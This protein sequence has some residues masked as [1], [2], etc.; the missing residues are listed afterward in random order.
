M[1]LDRFRLAPFSIKAKLQTWSILY[2]QLHCGL[3]CSHAVCCHALVQTTV[4]RI[5]VPNREP[6]SFYFRPFCRH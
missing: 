4:S 1:N 3:L 2:Y 5:H 6:S